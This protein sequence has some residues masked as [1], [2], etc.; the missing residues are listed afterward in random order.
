MQHELKISPFDLEM[1]LIEVKELQIKL[2]VE[3]TDGKILESCAVARVNPEDGT[4]TLKQAATPYFICV[5]DIKCVEFQTFFSYRGES[6]KIFS[7]E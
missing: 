7:V 3:L 6:A 2:N 5:S 4:V 1:I